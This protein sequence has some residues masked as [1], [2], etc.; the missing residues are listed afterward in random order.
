[1][2]KVEFYKIGTIKDQKLAFAVV[3]SEFETKWIWV[4][5]KTRSTWEIPGGR[6]EEGEDILNTAKRELFEETGAIDFELT[7]ICDYSVTKSSETV[8][9][10]TNA[11]GPEDSQT[12]F[13]RLYY[14]KVKELNP[15]L[16]FEIEKIQFCEELP[17]D[18]TYPEI[19]PHL[20][21]KIINWKFETST[22]I[23]NIVKNKQISCE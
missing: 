10:G 7:E 16:E 17:Q 23:K 5:H 19:Q 22:K 1:M 4:K 12:K 20:F 15:V 2:I 8:F 21:E 11:A 13:G 14:S 3:C 9:F 18:L 6:R